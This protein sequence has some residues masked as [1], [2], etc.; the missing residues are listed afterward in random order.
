MN[1]VVAGGD[2]LSADLLPAHRFVLLATTD[3]E[4]TGACLGTI[5]SVDRPLVAEIGGSSF[6]RAA[7][8]A[9]NARKESDGLGLFIFTYYDPGESG[10]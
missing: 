1:A 2:L 5:R 8:Q 9:Q 6:S 10:T 7:V 4:R 3:A